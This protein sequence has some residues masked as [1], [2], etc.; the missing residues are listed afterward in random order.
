MQIA[1]DFIHDAFIIVTQK[2]SA[3]SNSIKSPCSLPFFCMFLHQNHLSKLQ[4]QQHFLITVQ[5]T[6]FSFKALFSKYKLIHNFPRFDQFF[7][8]VKVDAMLLL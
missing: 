4:K 7:C 1:L 5:K 8:A 3:S 2:P 6:K